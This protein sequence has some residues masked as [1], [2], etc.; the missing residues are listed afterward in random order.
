VTGVGLLAAGFGLGSGRM[1]RMEPEVIRAVWKD[2]KLPSDDDLIGIGGTAKSRLY[3]ASRNGTIYVLDNK[4]EIKNEQNVGFG[5][6]QLRMKSDIE[7]WISANY[8][9]LY[10]YRGGIWEVVDAPTSEGLTALS[11]APDGTGWVGGERGSLFRLE[12]NTVTACQVYAPASVLSLVGLSSEE[13]LVTLVDGSVYRILEKG[14]L[15]EELEVPKTTS[16][17]RI[18]SDNG[19]QSLTLAGETGIFQRSNGP[20]LSKSRPK[21]GK[22][23]DVLG[24]VNNG[25]FLAGDRGSIF[26]QRDDRWFLSPTGRTHDIFALGRGLGTVWAAAEKGH[27]LKYLGNSS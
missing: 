9:R 10:T 7:P 4:G 5:L 15:L 23:N 20:W 18:L 3:M 24:T 19:L 14:N 26:H 8:G 27:Y 13:A 6:S 17:W 21:A 25:L 22:I 12:G 11:F 1:E 2:Y 16:A